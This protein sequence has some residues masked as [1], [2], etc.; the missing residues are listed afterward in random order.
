MGFVE[1]AKEIRSW[2]ILGI[3]IVVLFG[4]GVAYARTLLENKDKKID[5]LNDQLKEK[6]K[7][8]I[9]YVPTVEY[10]DKVKYKDRWKI[11]KEV[12]Y[13]EAPPTV[14]NAFDTY[15]EEC[16]KENIQPKI[17]IEDLHF[18]CTADICN[19]EDSACLVN[20]GFEI[21]KK[22]SV[23][24]KTFKPSVIGGYEVMDNAAMLGISIMDYKGVVAGGNVISDF[25]TAEHSGVGGFVGYRPELKK[26]KLNLVVGVGVTSHFDDL[27]RVGPQGFIGVNILDRE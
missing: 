4:M 11:K 22:E 24:K 5:A 13:I 27:S 1:T 6:P 18:T 20:D 17:S 14:V 16:E 9:K 12:E 3:V 15:C 23:I 8:E 21:R 7:V 26:W 19:Q 25:Q 2:I 10:V